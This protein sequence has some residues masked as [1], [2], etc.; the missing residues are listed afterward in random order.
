MATQLIADNEATPDM[1]SPRQDVPGGCVRNVRVGGRIVAFVVVIVLVA[2][3]VGTARYLRFASSHVT[4]DN[5]YLTTDVVRISPQVSGTVMRVLVEDNQYV[6]AGESLVVLDDA[7]YRAARDQAHGSY[8]AA[9]AQ[10]RAA[11]VG[12]KLASD[13]GVAL[14]TQAQGAVQQATGGIAGAGADVARAAAAVTTAEATAQG[15]Q[16]SIATAEAAVAVALASERKAEAGAAAAEAKTRNADATTQAARAAVDAADATMART[17]RDAERAQKL[18]GQ[19]AV[20]EQTYDQAVWARQAASAAVDGAK[21]LVSSAVAAAEAARQDVAAS[22]EQIAAAHATVTQARAQLAA[23]RQ[24]LRATRAGVRQAQAIKGSA[25]DTVRQAEAKRMQAVGQLQQ[26]RT[27]P[28]QVAINRSSSEQAAA[29]TE[30]ARAALKTVDLQIGYTRIIAPVSGRICKKSVE[31]GAL[32]QAG[33]PLMA[34]IPDDRVWVVANF[35]ETQ[36]AGV[37]AGC[38]VT[39]TVDSV[40]GCEYRGRVDSLS[41]ATGAT[42]A[43]LPPDNAT[44]NFTKVVQRVPVK[45]VIEPGQPGMDRLRAGLSA[46]ATVNLR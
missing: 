19:G 17:S 29:K 42:F 16:E 27:S 21:D 41:A 40:P 33:T 22:R 1:K 25:M 39:V 24:Q 15:A 3:G 10:A 46:V 32:V 6:H 30:Q 2:L 5:A 38:G 26:A 4:T 36:L 34:I 43:L 44:G 8:L 11:G 20:S 31:Q 14:V 35:K 37:R 13:T 12:V 7:M 23:A 45:I 28:H 18:V 9:V